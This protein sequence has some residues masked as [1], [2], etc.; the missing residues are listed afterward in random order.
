MVI[1]VALR[2]AASA[3]APSFPML[4]LPILQAR[5]GM[6]TVREKACQWALTGERSGVAHLSEVT[7][8][9]LRP[10]HSLLM[11]RPQLSRPQSWL[12]AKLP[13]EGGVSMCIDTKANTTGRRRT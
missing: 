1:C 5:G 11:T 6:G 2:M 12:P 10:S 3:E 8:L 9:P 7:A 13:Q 4:L